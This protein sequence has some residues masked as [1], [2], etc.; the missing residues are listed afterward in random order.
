MENSDY[1]CFQNKRVEK[2]GLYKRALEDCNLFPPGIYDLQNI[3][4]IFLKSELIPNEHYI[5]RKD[6]KYPLWKNYIHSV[7]P[8]IDRI[9]YLGQQKYCFI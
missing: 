1:P 7:R 9:S 5:Y 4:E 2:T 6:V 8:Y 3:Y